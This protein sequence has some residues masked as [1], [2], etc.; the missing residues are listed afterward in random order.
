MSNDVGLKTRVSEQ[1]HNDFPL[2][3]RLRCWINRA[4]EGLIM[5]RPW[6]WIRAKKPARR[7]HTIERAS[8]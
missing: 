8:F 7:G 2:L 6:P 3:A 4:E 5:G 1:T